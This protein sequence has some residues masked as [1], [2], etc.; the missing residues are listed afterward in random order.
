MDVGGVIVTNLVNLLCFD[1]F[2]ER[3]STRG[4]EAAQPWTGDYDPEAGWRN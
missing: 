2:L 3:V 1:G 4:R